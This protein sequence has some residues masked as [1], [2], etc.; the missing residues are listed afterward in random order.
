MT[1][2]II[3]FAGWAFVLTATVYFVITSAFP[4]LSYQQ[5]QFAAGGFWPRYAPYLL[6]HIIA[7]MTALLLGPFQFVPSIRKNYKKTHRFMGKT[8][9]IAIL[10]AAI[11]SLQMSINKITID[12]KAAVYGLGLFML[13]LVWVLSSAMAYWSARSRN[14]V[15]HREWMVRSYVITC[16]FTT[17]RLFDK[18]ITER[19]KIDPLTSAGIMAWACWSVPLIVTEVILQ[20]RKI[21]KGN[22]A[23]ADKAKRSAVVNASLD[24]QG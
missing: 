5:A 7:G 17:F 22:A 8:Y 14:F 10:V 19:F 6:V 3:N 9:L 24:I 18:I 16:A 15:Q 1:T 12:E 23:L 13:A 20:G 11:A 21:Q 4:Y 2:R